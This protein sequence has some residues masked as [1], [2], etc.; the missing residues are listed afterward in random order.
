[1]NFEDYCVRVMIDNNHMNVV[2][3]DLEETGLLQGR[4][5]CRGFVMSL[6]I[7]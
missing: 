1:V 2:C 5:S 3:F 6:R 7:S 4:I